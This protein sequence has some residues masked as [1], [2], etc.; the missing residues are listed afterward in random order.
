M[1]LLVTR[2]KA[3]A[4]E[5][6]A[7]LMARGHSVKIAPVLDVD[8]T[9]ADPIDLTDVQALI[10]TSKN[11]LRALARDSVF[12]QARALTVYA[13]G[14]GTAA[15]AKALGFQRI[16]KGPRNAGELVQVIAET[17]DVNAGSLLHLAGD[18]LAH[19]VAGDLSGLGFHVLA[20]IVY[21]MLPAAD[22]APSVVADLEREELDGVILLSPQ[23]A[24]IWC[25]L[26][27]ARDLASVSRSV[28]HLCLSPAVAAALAPLGRVPVAVAKE[29]NLDEMLAAI[30]AAA[31]NWR[32]D[33]FR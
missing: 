19:D 29:P 2:P 11:G 21:R 22:L 28:L 30:D 25:A 5:L 26:V 20:P 17:A 10:A 8:F 15:T 31:A 9:T 1:R 33:N 32:N 24:H 16:Y 23:T 14:P 7:H 27:R 6:Q 12:D 13:V 18:R 3:D 4:V